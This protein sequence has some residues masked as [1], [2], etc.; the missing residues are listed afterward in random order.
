M[1]VTILIL[2]KFFVN[3]GLLTKKKFI[4]NGTQE[5]NEN[6][7]GEQQHDNDFIKL[8]CA[9]LSCPGKV[10]SLSVLNKQGV[11]R[12]TINGKTGKA[13]MAEVT[14]WF[15]SGNYNLL[16]LGL[17]TQNLQCCF[18]VNRKTV[19]KNTSSNVHNLIAQLPAYCHLPLLKSLASV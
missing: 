14:F 8:Y 12:K 9:I 5:E 2:H 3:T 6:D 11:F 10:V 17:E 7:N 18:P 19:N 13:L 1:S 15:L 16:K 4:I